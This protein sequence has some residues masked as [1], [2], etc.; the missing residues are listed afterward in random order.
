MK[1]HMSSACAFC[2]L[3]MTGCYSTANP[4]VKDGVY[5]TRYSK[6][7]G[8]ISMGV[9][10]YSD[11]FGSMEGVDSGFGFTCYMPPLLPVQTIGYAGYILAPV[12]FV[13]AVV[14]GDGDA[15]GAILEGWD[16]LGALASID[17]RAG[18][19]DAL[20]DVTQNVLSDL[21]MDLGISVSNHNDSLAGGELTCAGLLL[22][23]RLAG[24]REKHPRVYV[25]G[26][27]GWYW[28]E[29]DN[30]PD[31]SVPGS[32]FGAA[33]EFL[34]PASNTALGV[35]VRGSFFAGND[36]SGVRI[37]GGSAQVILDLGCYW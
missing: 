14:A 29:Y 22:G 33:L 37:D 36:D 3:V 2:L 31:A 35:E 11:F 26:G 15:A 4:S 20:R 5:S 25:C 1:R 21:S 24:P 17:P 12:L 16:E 28:F 34:T 18:A 9:I 13:G 19:T 30:R 32:Y 23:V 10:P 27:A 8:H 7:F 6:A